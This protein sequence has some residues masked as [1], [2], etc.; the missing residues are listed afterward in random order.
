MQH[1]KQA[2]HTAHQVGDRYGELIF[3]ANQGSWMLLLG[4]I[5]EV[6]QML[7]EL[8]ELK[9]S[10]PDESTGNLGSDQLYNFWLA[11]KGDFEQALEYAQSKREKERKS[12]DLQRLVNSLGIIILVSI[13]TGDL[14]QGRS[15]AD[16]IVQLAE[17]GIT[18]KA[19]AFSRSSII[20]SREGEIQPAKNQY[21]LAADELEKPQKVEFD[22][23]WIYWAQAELFLAEGN[24][25]EAWLAF[26]KLYATTLDNGFIWH[27]NLLLTEWGFALLKHGNPEE[28]ARAKALLK[29][30]SEKFQDMGA[31]GFVKLIGD[32]LVDSQ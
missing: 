17:K 12:G 8:Q 27:A 32:K 22:R 20:F 3:R 31:D 24:L 18:S 14:V 13:S 9:T 19:E 21:K 5:H 29:E 10:L 6:E 4:Q 23:M 7:S 1:I 16:E 15:A 25:G 26:E 11:T 30:A 28:Q 2:A